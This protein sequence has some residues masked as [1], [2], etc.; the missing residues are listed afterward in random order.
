M[1]NFLHAWSTVERGL[2][3]Y[4]SRTLGTIEGVQGYNTDSMPRN[5][6]DDGAA[7]FI[8]QFKIDGGGEVVHRNDRNEINGGAWKMNAEF[9]AYC[10]TDYVAKQVAGQVLD[11]LPALPTDGIDGLA[12]LYHTEWPTRTWTTMGVENDERAGD[13]RRFVEL[14]IN[15]ECAFGNTGRIE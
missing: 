2:M 6:P 12:M 3:D 13:T 11:A 9:R 7:F 4:F 8:W 10:S 5:M 14:I 1:S 15:M